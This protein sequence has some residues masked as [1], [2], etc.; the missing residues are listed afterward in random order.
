MTSSFVDVRRGDVSESRHRI[1][2][3]IVHADRGLVAWA[4][5]PGFTTFARSAVKMFQALPLV[6]DG[7]VERWKLSEHELAI[8]TA[9]HGGQP[10]HVAAVRSILAKVGVSERALACGP[11]LPLHQGSAD[12]LMASGRAPTRLHNNCSGKHAGMLALA[13]LRG[14]PLEGYH[15]I[16]H[17]VQ[18]RMAKTIAMWANVP[19]SD[20]RWAVDGCGVPTFALPLVVLARACARFARSARDGDSGA[21]RLVRAMTAHPEYVAGSGRLCTDLMRATAGRLFAKVGAEGVYLAGVPDEGIG[22]ALKVEDGAGRAVEPALV[23]VLRQERL[24][25]CDV[26]D[27]LVVYAHPQLRN[28]RDEVVG[29]IVAHLTVH[30]A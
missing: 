24:I 14:W 7:G 29:D 13:T 22:V 26:A 30:R 1:H 5:E 28:T 20:L 27:R 19:A 6:E 15:H 21:R 4:G 25:D 3:A 9:S 8:T 18:Q 17:S 23:A 2:A 10:F 11:S 12:A 16:D